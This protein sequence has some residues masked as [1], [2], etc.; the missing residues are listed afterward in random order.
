MNKSGTLIT[1]VLL[2]FGIA[3]AAMAADSPQA[4]ATTPATT[5]PPGPPT[6]GPKEDQRAIDTSPPKTSGKHTTHKH[7]KA[8]KPATPA[9]TTTPAPATNK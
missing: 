6:V 2:T 5:Q 9:P 8:H 4:V 7:K 3:A 1:S